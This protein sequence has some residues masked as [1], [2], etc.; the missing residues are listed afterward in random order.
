MD[1]TMEEV[2][3]EQRT[4]EK[5]VTMLR[6]ARCSDWPISIAMEFI[7]IAI[8]CTKHA[9]KHRPEVKQVLQELEKLELKV[10]N[11]RQNKAVV[12]CAVQNTEPYELVD[13]RLQVVSVEPEKEGNVQLS[14]E[15]E[16]LDDDDENRKGEGKVNKNMDSQNEIESNEENM[17]LTSDERALNKL[18]EIENFDKLTIKEKT[19]ETE[20]ESRESLEEIS[21][22]KHREL[23]DEMVAFENRK[24]Q[25]D[26][27]ISNEIEPQY[28]S[29]DHDHH[30]QH[31]QNQFQDQQISS[32]QTGEPHVCQPPYQLDHGNQHHYVAPPPVESSAHSIGPIMGDSVHTPNRFHPMSGSY[33]RR[34]PPPVRYDHPHGYNNVNYTGHPI[35]MPY[36]YADYRHA[37]LNTTRQES[38]PF[39]YPDSIPYRQYQYDGPYLRHP[40]SHP[41]MFINSV[42]PPNPNLHSASNHYPVRDPDDI[43]PRRDFMY[44]PQKKQHP[45]Q[46]G[47]QLQFYSLE[48]YPPAQPM[49]HNVYPPP[50]MEACEFPPNNGNPSLSPPPDGSD[51]YHDER[52]AWQQQQAW[53]AQHGRS[54]QQQYM[55]QDLYRD[56]G[57]SQYREMSLRWAAGPPPSQPYAARDY[58]SQRSTGSSGEESDV[59]RAVQHQQQQK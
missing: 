46:N 2:L 50:M 27:V 3:D 44:Y 25:N 12:K 37:P 51:R 31:Q 49:H 34:N 39:N 32:C 6:D 24:Q 26:N 16:E 18:R 13:E 38:Y 42:P 36:S 28:M 1:Y 8:K 11:I 5:I 33:E 55:Q 9:P 7:E 45:S 14:K 52:I 58:Q 57:P 53:H 43:E 48:S 22:R 40:Q 17:Q 41:S 29:L 35:S 30:H 54:P 47:S 21:A 56:D 59:S 4:P 19:D 15:P 23:E 10:Q 20:D